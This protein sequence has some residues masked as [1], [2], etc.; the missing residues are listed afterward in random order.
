[1][2]KAPEWNRYNV[3][4]KIVKSEP[5]D[6][7]SCLWNNKPITPYIL[8]YILTTRSSYRSLSLQV[9]RLILSDYKSRT[10]Y[11]NFS[12]NI[13]FFEKNEEIGKK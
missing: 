7:F 1:M 5:T 9:V 10:Q 8:I 4:N 11:Y 6:S 12:F 13:N 2:N 3:T